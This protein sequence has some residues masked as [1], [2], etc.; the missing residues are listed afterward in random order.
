MFYNETDLPA[1]EETEKQGPRL[2]GKNEKEERQKRAQEKKSEGQKEADGLND[3]FKRRA[4]RKM[5]GGF[6]TEKKWVKKAA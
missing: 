4:L 5:R 3:L 1:E 2:P 6:F